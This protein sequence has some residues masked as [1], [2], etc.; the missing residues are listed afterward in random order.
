MSVTDD[1]IW[2]LKAEHPS[3]D[4]FW[5]Y[6]QEHPETYE[7]FVEMAR[8]AK[9]K[10]YERVGIKW[11]IE[12]GR[13]E[14]GE[15]MSMGSGFSHDFQPIYTRLIMWNEPDLD[16]IFETRVLSYQRSPA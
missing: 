15:D 4:E 8:R 14:T 2:A 9:A 11:L 5:A 10:G 1:E 13:W 3:W 16:G 6:H 12:V 7:F